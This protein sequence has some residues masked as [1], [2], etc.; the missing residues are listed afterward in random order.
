MKRERGTSLIF[1]S[2][3]LAVVRQL[4]ERVLVMYLGKVVESGPAHSV[5]RSTATSVYA[6]CC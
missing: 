2:H 1:V 4:C 3:N 6:A 5:L